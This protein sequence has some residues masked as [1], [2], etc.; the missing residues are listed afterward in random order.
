M[1]GQMNAAVNVKNPT[2]PEAN[3]A[4]AVR[5]TLA[6]SFAAA[7]C[8]ED[9]YRHWLLHGVLPAEVATRLRHLPFSPPLLGGLSGKR[10]LHNDKRHYFDAANNARF[11]HCGA[12]AEAFQSSQVIDTIRRFTGLDLTGAYVR[13]EYAQD[14]DG[15]WLEPHTDLGVKKFTMLIYLSDGPEQADLGTD[16]YRAPGVWAKRT[17]FEHNSALIFV[18]G[19]NSWHGL[20]RRP[21]HGV[22]K[23]LIMNYVTDDWRAREQLAYPNDPVRA[24]NRDLTAAAAS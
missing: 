12:V 7:R 21:I 11:P 4:E 2:I 18:P 10:E 14:E 15:F 19:D 13:I 9:P 22:R 20:E 16:I 6:A 23:T 5:Q 24:S 17:S 3:L 1:S 8:V